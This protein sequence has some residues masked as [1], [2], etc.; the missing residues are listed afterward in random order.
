MLKTMLNS[1]NICI[2][3][4]VDKMELSAE[5]QV[6]LA[7]YIEYQKDLP[8]ME[9]VTFKNLEMD[10]DIF[11]EALNK[12][13][14]KGYMQDFISARGSNNKILVPFLSG[15][16]LSKPALTECE[17]LLESL[18]FSNE[19]AESISMKIF[20]SVKEDIK[21]IIARYWAEMSK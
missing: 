7:L 8:N 20:K 18:K 13:D 12:L 19:S 9:N 17:Q 4:G 1:G 14:K 2:S 3:K 21:D 10:K 11:N 5:Q 16:S 15:V 6:L